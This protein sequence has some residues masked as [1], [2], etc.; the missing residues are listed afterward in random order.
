[1]VVLSFN[2]VKLEVECIINDRSRELNCMNFGVVT[3]SLKIPCKY[4]KLQVLTFTTP[5]YYSSCSL[6]SSIPRSSLTN[7]SKL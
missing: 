5:V 3:I 2:D 1:M 7:H 4:Q 6:N